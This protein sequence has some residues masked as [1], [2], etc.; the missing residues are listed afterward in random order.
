[1]PA[2]LVPVEPPIRTSDYSSALKNPF[3]Y[4]L[5]RRLGMA[6]CLYEAEALDEG[7]WTHKAQE[8]DTFEEPAYSEASRERY[9]SA[10][11]AA[12]T[13]KEDVAYRVLGW[14]Y[15]SVET[16]KMQTL[17][18]AYKALALYQTAR[19]LPSG[20]F[21]GLQRFIS[22]P[23]IT[24]IGREMR[25]EAVL[26]GRPVVGILDLLLLNGLT[27][28]LLPIDT[29]TTK[30]RAHVRTATCAIEPQTL[31]YPRLVEAN[32][33]H[34]R[35]E[36]PD[37]EIRGIAGFCHWVCERPEIRL[38]G[39]DRDFREVPHTL[40]SGPRKGQIEIRKEWTSDEP[41]FENY[42]QRVK[43][44]FLGQGDY[45]SEASLLQVEPRVDFSMVPWENIRDRSRDVRVILDVIDRWRTMEPDPSLFPKN[46]EALISNGEL[47]TFSDFY[48]TEPRVWPIL[49]DQHGIVV[50]HREDLEYGEED[51]P[52][53]NE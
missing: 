7:S 21:R 6:H 45:L 29:K 52:Q 41:K 42:I 31:I 30:L 23:H 14:P 35:A 27:G 44:W 48:L 8:F 34:I 2:E 33:D 20:N 36:N 46:P 11:A 26:D 53:D 43:D 51:P 25:L 17:Q 24:V 28:L 5:H 4:F 16:L 15:E 37:L 3:G 12:V 22:Q 47:T 50:R 13:A 9:E 39:K 49:M 32:L 10:V 18:R 1:M 19:N 40:K 38:S